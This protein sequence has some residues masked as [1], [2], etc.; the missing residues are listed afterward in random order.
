[1]QHLLCV[2]V[3]LQ[4]DGDLSASIPLLAETGPLSLPLRCLARRA[5]PS[6]NPAPI[7]SLDGR[8]GGVMLAATAHKAVTIS[9]AGA[10]TILYDIKVTESVRRRTGQAYTA[11]DIEMPI[12]KQAHLGAV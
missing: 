8:A 2:C 5:L 7:V 12:C 3:V 10:L 11:M 6:V 1:M 4:V 9:N